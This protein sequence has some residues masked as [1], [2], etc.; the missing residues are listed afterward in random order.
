MRHSPTLIYVPLQVKIVGKNQVVAMA[1]YSCNS[2]FPVKIFLNFYFELN[3]KQKD[4]L[5]LVTEL[6]PS[7]SHKISLSCQ[8]VYSCTIVY[9]YVHKK[10]E[11]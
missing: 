11:I 8:R 7:L 6:W 3:A 1:H 10:A 9:C 4:R 2:T 5:F